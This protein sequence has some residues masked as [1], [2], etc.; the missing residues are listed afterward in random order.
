MN[1]RNTI[2]P[3]FDIAEKLYPEV[4]KPIMDYTDFCNENGDENNEE[5]KKLEATFHGMTGK[6]MLRF[7][8]WEWWEGEGA[9]V[10]A[11]RISLPDP[12]KI[13]DISK[14]ELF[15]IVRSKKGKDL[16]DARSR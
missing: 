14:D 3:Q 7:D 6:D 13:G 8:L 4:L 2:E 16:R 15:E 10:L 5:Y 1:L 12:I 9:E 11:F